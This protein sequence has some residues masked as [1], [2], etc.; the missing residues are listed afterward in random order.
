MNAKSEKKEASEKRMTEFQEKFR[1]VIDKNGR[2][3]FVPI[4]N[5]KPTQK[6]VEKGQWGLIVFILVL[7]AVLLFFLS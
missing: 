3:H 4:N 6:E 2:I 1:T 5:N 7:I